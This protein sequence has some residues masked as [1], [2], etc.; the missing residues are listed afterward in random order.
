VM[1]PQRVGER[2]RATPAEQEQGVEREAVVHAGS[3]CGTPRT[4][5]GVARR[6]VA[7]GCTGLTPDR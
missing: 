1:E 7:G 6:D 5:S 2:E 3:K 4:A